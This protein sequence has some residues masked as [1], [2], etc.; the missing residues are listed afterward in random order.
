SLLDRYG[1]WGRWA[2]QV[3]L[4][5]QNDGDQVWLL[6]TGDDITQRYFMEA[7]LREEQ[8]RLSTYINTMQTLLIICDE[9]GHVTRVNL[10]AQQLL[11]IPEDQI[12]GYPFSYLIP[13]QA[14]STVE[15]EWQNLLSRHNGN[16]SLEFPVLSSTGKEHIISWRMTRLT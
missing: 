6:V 4:W 12:N 13:Q 5:Q 2:M 7:Q 9:N 11:Q 14:T 3:R 8:Q 1:E 15:R 10:Q 16:L